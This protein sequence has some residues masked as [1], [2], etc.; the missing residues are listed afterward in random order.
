MATLSTFVGLPLSVPLG[1]VSLAGAS[2]SGVTTVLTE[3]YQKKL[4]TDIVTSAIAVVETS[5][6][7]QSSDILQHSQNRPTGDRWLKH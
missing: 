7:N 6:P 3:E 2:V 4:A 5:V 1:A